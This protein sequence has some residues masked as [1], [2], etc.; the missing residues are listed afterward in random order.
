MNATA[1][2]LPFDETFASS[3]TERWKIVENHRQLIYAIARELRCSYNTPA[4]LD[5]LFGYGCIGL[6][7]AADRFRPD[8]GIAFRHYAY[9]RI[10]GAMI[11]GLRKEGWQSRRHYEAERAEARAA[12]RAAN[13]DT[14]TTEQAVREVGEPP[15]VVDEPSRFAAAPLL[16]S[17]LDET[18]PVEAQLDVDDLIDLRRGLA[19]LPHLERSVLE[20][21]YL[22]DCTHQE[23][24]NELGIDRSWVTKLHTRGLDLLKRFMSDEP[25]ADR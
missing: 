17:E 22:T 25:P 16:T 6:L 21:Y 24:A 11:D 8:R 3:P 10:R 23:I 14:S 19:R 1:R 4:G 2:V 5:D 12:A 15:R 7:D 18:F 20:R 9:A 13:G